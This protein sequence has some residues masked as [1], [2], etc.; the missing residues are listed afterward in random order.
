MEIKH[1]LSY[2]RYTSNL[3][4]SRDTIYTTNQLTVDF[5]YC[6]LLTG[7]LSLAIPP[8]VG[9]MSTRDRKVMLC[10]CGVK[11]GMVPVWVVGKTV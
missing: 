6:G 11:A 1:Y 10:H 5:N 2:S 8:W 7:Q 4:T 9:A 3:Q